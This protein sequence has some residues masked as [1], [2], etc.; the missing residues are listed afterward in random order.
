ALKALGDAKKLGQVQVVG[1]DTNEETLKG[2]E[3]G[4]V[5]ATMMQAAYNIGF[6]A[7]RVLGDAARGQAA[8]LPMFQTQYLPCDTVNKANLE[9]TRQQLAHPRAG[10]NAGAPPSPPPVTAPATAPAA[11]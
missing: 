1:F 2:I 6:D 10:A 7:V 4:N 5:A 3:D 9:A 11:P 8:S